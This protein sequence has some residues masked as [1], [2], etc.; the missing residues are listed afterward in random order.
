MKC[1]RVLTSSNGVVDVEHV[2]LSAPGVRVLLNPAQL[3]VLVN[4]HQKEN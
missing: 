2:V 4:L 1:K 3:V